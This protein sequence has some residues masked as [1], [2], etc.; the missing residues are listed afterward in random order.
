MKHCEILAPAGGEQSAVVALK[1]GADAV[2]LGLSRFS[3]RAGAEN[4]DLPALL[5][6]A[7]FAHLL[8]AKVYVALNT[9][10][11]DGET[12]DFFRTAAEVW[13]AG[14]DAV[15]LQDIF[16]GKRLKEAYPQMVLHLSTQ[17]G[18]NNVYGAQLA[19]EYGFSRI[20][21]ARETPLS[22]IGKIAKTV[23]TEVFVQGALCSS[24]SGQCYFSS[25]A[26]N[27][28]GN[29]GQCKQPCRKRYSVDRSGY[30]EKAYALSLSDLSMGEEVE[31]LLDAGV[32]SLK[33]EGRMR[34]DE[35]VASAVAY[36]RA[37]VDGRES[38]EAFSRLKRSYNRGDYTCGLAFGQSGDLLSRNVQGHIGEKVGTV[39]F[40]N[41]KPF[42]KSDYRSQQGDGFKILRKDR[43]VGGGTYA[44]SGKGG[45]FLRT[46]SAVASGDEVRVTTDVAGGAASL[47]AD[48][49]REITLSLF[50]NKGERPCVV[51]EGG[52]FYGDFVLE[53]AEKSPLSEEELKACFSKTD[54]LP[55]APRF[56]SVQTDGVFLPK[57]QLNAFRRSFYEA[58]RKTLGRPQDAADD[59]SNEKAVRGTPSGAGMR[60][61]GGR[62]F[63]C[64]VAPVK[65]E[66]RAVITADPDKVSADIVIFKPD[67]YADLS[68]ASHIEGE[69][70][71]YLPPFFTADDEALIE[72][73]L[74]LFDG[75]YCEGYYGIAFAK[76]YRKA[77]FAGTGFN[78]TNRY[79]VKGVKEAG[80]KY[81]ALSK[82]LTKSEQDALRAE[83]AFVLTAGAIKLMD[84]CYCPFERTCHDCDRRGR[85]A[86]KDEGGREFSLRRYRFSGAWC[87]FEVYNCADL[88]T[89]TEAN[90]LVDCTLLPDQRI[91]D[92]AGNDALLRKLLKNVT[93]GHENRSLL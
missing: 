68:A 84:L 81:F 74:P 88:L 70:F 55:L 21:L 65:G 47:T 9:L 57:S 16:L 18:C 8:G 5:R 87:R 59:G 6:T 40:C 73:A 12:E 44:G 7:E 39:S 51:W 4:F 36:Y 52:E 41:G 82:E 85:Y 86:L 17:A 27:H 67:D 19:C 33:I 26:G 35:Y 43:E 42:C 15:L 37:L 90:I 11:K 76:K 45:F 25:F 69:R 3:A 20:V 49:R 91:V 56:R 28:S 24:F 60:N 92:G 31:K 64:A 89:K 77:L 63:P 58:V 22:E 34:R 30:G 10:V 1:S 29:R 32:Y 53:G 61:L 83:G 72:K 2:Y 54:L 62:P 93:S 23:E 14:A 80:A 38:D 79:A 75:I 50:F 46:D 13:N 78:L 71:L 66:K 48:R